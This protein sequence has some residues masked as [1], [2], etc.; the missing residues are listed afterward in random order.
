MSVVCTSLNSS[1]MYSGIAN[2]EEALY[3]FF[4]GPFSK[5]KNICIHKLNTTDNVIL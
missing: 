5:N 2:A 4:E 3:Q 1:E